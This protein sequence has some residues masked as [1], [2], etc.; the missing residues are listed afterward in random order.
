M[1]RRRRVRARQPHV[2][3]D[4]PRLGAEADQREREHRAARAPAQ[5]GGGRPEIDE[6]ERGRPRAEPE[7]R[8]EQER[9]PDLGHPEVPVAGADRLRI[10]VVGQHQEIGGQ[11]HALPREQEGHHVVGERHQAGGEQEQVE[12]RPEA[13]ERVAARVPRGVADAVEGRGRRDHADQGQE[14][15][16]ERVHPQRDAAR[17]P[18]HVGRG[19]GPDR[20]PGERLQ[21]EQQ[22]GRRAGHRARGRERAAG[23]MAAAQERRGGARA[24]GAEHHREEEGGHGSRR[25]EAG[26]GRSG[27]R[28]G[29]GPARAD[30][31]RRTRPPG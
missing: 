4:Q 17:E 25:A 20:A 1:A 29:S 30:S 8:G 24:V 21:P 7:E 6:I 12:R 14:E 9:E 11:R 26:A 2:E 16:A 13:A 5:P 3:R 10:L 22:P 18:D 27:C 31:R 19:E 28:G 15:R 23:A